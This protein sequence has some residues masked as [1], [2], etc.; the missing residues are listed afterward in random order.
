MNRLHLNQL[1]DT[2]EHT[3]QA[4]LTELIDQLAPAEPQLLK[5]I[6]AQHHKQRVEQSMEERR[7]I[8]EHNSS[9]ADPT[10]L[11]A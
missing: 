10:R 3:E 1:V 8:L 9:F 2:I 5:L 11:G 6:V 7:V 4:Q